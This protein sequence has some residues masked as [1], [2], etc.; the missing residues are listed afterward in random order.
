MYTGYREQ[1]TSHAPQHRNLRHARRIEKL[2]SLNAHFPLQ[3]PANTRS[4]RQ[5]WEALPRYA[6]RKPHEYMELSL[7]RISKRGSK[8][9]EVSKINELTSPIIHIHSAQAAQEQF[10][11]P[12]ASEKQKRMIRML[13]FT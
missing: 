13:T 7:R 12:A 3:E 6:F 5:L 8:R 10:N 11:F 4:T 1:P 9:P 2:H